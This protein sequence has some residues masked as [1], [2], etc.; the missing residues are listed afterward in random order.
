MHID[1]SPIFPK[2]EITIGSRISA[3]GKMMDNYLS[4][5][6][7]IEF[8]FTTIYLILVFIKW[9]TIPDGMIDVGLYIIGTILMGLILVFSIRYDLRRRKKKKEKKEKKKDEKK[10]K[11]SKT[12][13]ETQNIE[14]KEEL[15]YVNKR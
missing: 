3:V 4:K 7:L 1:L 11:K 2:I 14:K 6:V 8:I 10:K 5:F 15:S 12:S 13:S 9:E